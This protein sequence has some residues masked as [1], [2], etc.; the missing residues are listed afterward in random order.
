[1]SFGMMNYVLKSSAHCAPNNVCSTSCDRS[2]SVCARWASRSTFFKINFGMLA[3]VV[4]LFL[5]LII[6][7]LLICFL[8]VRVALADFGYPST[9]R[10]LLHIWPLL[11][12]ALLRLVLMLALRMS[13]KIVYMLAP[14]VPEWPLL[15][16]VSLFDFL[17]VFAIVP[18]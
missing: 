3:C 5:L 2:L 9:D 4:L 6:L 18:Q 14:P 8:A 13:P 11:R 10:R 12:V 1:M 16:A 17:V 15:S 7:I